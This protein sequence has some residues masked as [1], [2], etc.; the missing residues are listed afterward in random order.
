MGV[1]AGGYPAGRLRGHLE[2]GRPG[3]TVEHTFFYPG[4]EEVYTVHLQVWP[5]S[6]AGAG[7]AGFRVYGP[8]GAVHIVGGAQSGLQPNVSAD[9]T[10]RNRG[11]HVVQI[12]NA[13]ESVPIDYELRILRGRPEG[14]PKD[15]SI[16]GP[17]FAYAGSYTAPGGGGK[18][19]GE[20]VYGFRF[21]PASGTLR[22]IEAVGGL[23]QPSYVTVDPLGRFAYAVGEVSMWEGQR[24]GLV[25]AYAIDPTNGRLS[26]LN[27]QIAQGP[28]TNFATV[29]PSGR[30]LLITNYSGAG[31]G[32]LP[33]RGDGS[34][35]AVSYLDVHEG[36]AGPH[37]AQTSPHPH[38]IL[39]DP[40]GQ[41]ALSPDLGLDRVYV[42]QLDAAKARLVPNDP[43]Y[44][45]M[46]LGAGSRHVTFHPSGRFAYV[47]GER[48]TTI[49][50]FAWDGVNGTLEKLQT[51]P[52]VPEDFTG[53]K[54]SSHI[55]VHPEG[56]F[57]Y[58]C[59][60]RH[61]SLAVFGIDQGTG[62]LSLIGWDP[63]GGEI[64][65]SFNFDPW[66]N[67]IYTCNQDSD[68]I[69]QLRIDHNTGRTQIVDSIQVATPTSIVFAQ[70]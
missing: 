44:F 31:V 50:A 17:I 53:Q 47:N 4:N 66:G 70:P 22:R 56:R 27:R 33:I 37:P 29:D 5:D 23:P 2:P 11:R 68:V 39:F 63:T 19:H 15:A 24:T 43:P 38:Q 48:D 57:L 14:Q 28:I 52:T 30:F 58:V 36:P 59:N 6:A 12:Y 18:G 65:R 60:R 25:D 16:N 51:L 13:S 69:N 9:V 61:D 20:G 21:D 32:L 34:L 7:Q 67:F 1:G 41:W 64:T 10:S 3:R 26:F 8:N 42:Y 40:T 55:A 54:W 45:Q 46:H 49:T 35:D 62:K